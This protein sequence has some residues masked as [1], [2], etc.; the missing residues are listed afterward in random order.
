M[1]DAREY[2]ERTNHT[3][4]SIRRS[5]VTMDP[6]NKPRPTKRYLD[7][8]RIELDR[9]APPWDPTLSLVAEARA[10][11]LAGTEQDRRTPI[12]AETLA[13]LCYA[14]T[15]ITNEVEAD[16]QTMRFRAA[17]CTGKLYHVDCYLVCGDLP[18][19][20]AGIYHFDPARFAFHVVC[21]GDFRG[22]LAGAAGDAVAGGTD[23]GDGAT[24]GAGTSE[25]TTR[26]ADTRKSAAGDDTTPSTVAEAPVTV[27]ATS[28]WWRN[29]WKYRERTYRHAFWDGGT[30]L[31]NLLAAAHGLDLRAQVVAGFVDDSVASVLG[32]DPKAEAPLALVPIGGRPEDSVAVG[33]KPSTAVDPIDHD[34]APLSSDPRDHPLIH[35]AWAASTLP[36]A[37]SVTTWRTSA[38]SLE[39]PGTADAGDGERIPLDPVDHET[40]SGRPLHPVVVRRGS[41]RSFTDEGPSRRAVGTILDRATRGVPGDWNGGSADGFDFLDAYVLATGVDGVADGTY[42]YHPEEEALERIGDVDRETKTG[43]ALNQQWAGRAHLNVYLL[44]NVDRVV[45]GL[46]NRGYRLAQLEAGI[47]LGRLY[48]A[49]YAHRDLGGTGLT[50]Y[51]GLVADHLAPRAGGQTPM[52]MFCFGRRAE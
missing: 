13:T 12:D 50:F 18:T 14:A 31:A 39:D 48:L 40:A 21:E 34:T 17:S 29:A 5:T 38:R 1:T 3:P 37:D 10:D 30:I 19:L 24:S 41:A 7:V 9:I 43:L 11:P 4:E 26:G 46:G 23:S 2:H 28:T 8:D 27:V 33:R 22:V 16:G 47:V 6:A 32:V 51:D 15:G 36:D 52:T 25:R 35:E 49:T 44:A 45:D 42:H 20:E